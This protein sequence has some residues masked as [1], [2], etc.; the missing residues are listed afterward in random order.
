MLNFTWF[1]TNTYL[2]LNLCSKG[3]EKVQ[4]E[5]SNCILE[6]KKCIIAAQIS[7]SISNQVCTFSAPICSSSSAILSFSAPIGSLSASIHSFQLRYALSQPWLKSKTPLYLGI[8]CFFLESP[9][10]QNHQ[11]R[12]PGSQGEASKI[13][14]LP[15]RLFNGLFKSDVG[16]FVTFLCPNLDMSERPIRPINMEYFKGSVIFM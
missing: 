5:L 9:N 4:W 3:A 7:K 10:V 1:L 16:V 6:L 15:D 14:N 2:Y 8:L 13:L 12:Y 11:G